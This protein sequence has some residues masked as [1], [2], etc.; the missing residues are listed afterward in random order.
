MAETIL[1]PRQG[2]TVESCVILSWMQRLSLSK[3]TEIKS[4]KLIVL[5]D[6]A[7]AEHTGSVSVTNNYVLRGRGAD[8][9]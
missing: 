4:T 9:G 8:L 3:K 5:N 1:M 2:N 6:A 7:A